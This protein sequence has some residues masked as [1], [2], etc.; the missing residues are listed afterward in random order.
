MKSKLAGEKV[1]AHFCVDLKQSFCRFAR[2]Q[3]QHWKN[4]TE[5][6]SIYNY[7]HVLLLVDIGLSYLLRLGQYFLIEQTCE[8]ILLGLIAAFCLREFT[9]SST[10]TLRN[11]SR[12]IIFPKITTESNLRSRNILFINQTAIP[13]TTGLKRNH[14]IDACLLILSSL[15]CFKYQDLYEVEKGHVQRQYLAIKCFR[16]FLSAR[17]LVF[18]LHF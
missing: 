14:G 4:C 2:R 13:P 7:L 3:T 1:K 17:P 10:S 5:R 9:M 18:L 15:S 11:S 6:G 8:Y 16:Q 12:I